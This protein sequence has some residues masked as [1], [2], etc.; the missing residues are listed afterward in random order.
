MSNLR[1][2]INVSCDKRSCMHRKKI[3]FSVLVF[4]FT[5]C[6]NAQE[7]PNI[8]VYKCSELLEM[9]SREW[10]TDSLANNEFRI[11]HYR[12]FLKSIID[13]V[14]QDSI[15]NKIGKP[16]KIRKTN[17]GT[18]F[19]YYFYNAKTLHPGKD[20]PLAI[21][22]IYFEFPDNKKLLSRIWEGDMD[23]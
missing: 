6:T 21:W 8:S 7:L 2:L 16:D 15:L 13:S 10:K 5:V 4:L 12:Y 20:G 23:L 9:Y 17:H 22:Y 14:H 3:F 19:L 1:K 11:N 18:E